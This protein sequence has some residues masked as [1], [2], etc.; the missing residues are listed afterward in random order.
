MNLIP[1]DLPD[2]EIEAEDGCEWIDGVTV[3][4]PMGME[5][6]MIAARL[7]RALSTHAEANKL[8]EVFQGDLGYQINVGSSRRVRKPDVSF[9][10]SAR[11]RDNPLLRGNARIAPELAVE[12]I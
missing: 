2:A 12:V 1:H 10:S 8:G 9:I 7:I 4:K 6:S 11:L 5:S 3:E